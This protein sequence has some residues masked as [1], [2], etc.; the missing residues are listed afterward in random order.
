[1]KDKDKKTSQQSQFALSYVT[2]ITHYAKTLGDLNP[3]YE[4]L[5]IG[6]NYNSTSITKMGYLDNNN[7]GIFVKVR[8]VVEKED[9]GEAQPLQHKT[10]SSFRCSISYLIL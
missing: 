5:A 6:V 3:R 4:L 8:G 10:R 1:M 2:L 9:E 7:D